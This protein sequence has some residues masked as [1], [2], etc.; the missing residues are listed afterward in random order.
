MIFLHSN[1]F[2]GKSAANILKFLLYC[3][4]ATISDLV[5]S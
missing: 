3:V 5:L 4:V 1:K 2:E